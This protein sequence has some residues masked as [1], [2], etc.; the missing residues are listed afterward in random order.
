M[1]LNHDCIRDVMIYI[2]NNCIYED[3][4]RG[5][6]SIHSRVFYEIIHDEK[7]SSRYTEDEIRYVVAQLYFED[8]VIATMT[9][10]TL[11]FRQFDV[12]SL[13]FKGHEFLDN[14][15]DDTIWK[16]TKKFVG[17]RLNSAS[18]AIIGN[19]AGKLALEALTSGAAPK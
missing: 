6:R 11:N 14:I 12:D 1:K 2:E 17:E 15:K 4:S 13:S 10:E 8:M 7:L 16:K 9:P 18:L 19:V 3:D 5:N